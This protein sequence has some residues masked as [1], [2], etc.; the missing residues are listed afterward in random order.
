MVCGRIGVFSVRRETTLLNT[1]AC[2]D[3]TLAFFWILGVGMFEGGQTQKKI[4]GHTC[5]VARG[6]FWYF[7]R[8][9]L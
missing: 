9:K 8:I 7:D 1:E 5:I 2:V 6:T 3:A 4:D